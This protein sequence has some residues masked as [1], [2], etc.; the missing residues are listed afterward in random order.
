MQP[1]SIILTDEQVNDICRGLKQNAAKIRFLQSLGFTVKRR[2]DGS[3]LVL[4]APAPT[5][6][7]T[8]PRWTR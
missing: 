5:H 6:N 2:P 3:P 7:N 4:A 8:Q 1:Q